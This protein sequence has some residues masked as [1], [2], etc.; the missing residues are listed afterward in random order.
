M[1]SADF[2]IPD[3]MLLLEVEGGTWMQAKVQPDG[4]VITGHHS[5]PVGYE[6]DCEKYNAAAILGWRVLRFTTQMVNDRR[7]LQTIQRALGL[8]VTPRTW[9]EVAARQGLFLKP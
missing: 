1:W 2:A 5:H 7:A 3:R 9:E 6:K 4:T 8:D